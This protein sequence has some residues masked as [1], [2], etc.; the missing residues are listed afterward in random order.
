MRRVASDVS[1]SDMILAN[2]K[3]PR[4]KSILSLPQ[5]LASTIEN[6]NFSQSS[7][8]YQQ[9]LR[10]RKKICD[11]V[12]N[13][14]HGVRGRSSSST[15]KSTSSVL[16]VYDQLPRYDHLSRSARRERRVLRKAS[17]HTAITEEDN[18]SKDTRSHNRSGNRMRET[19]IKRMCARTCLDRTEPIPKWINIEPTDDRPPTNS[20]PPLRPNPPPEPLKRVILQHKDLIP[21]TDLAMIL[22]KNLDG[23]IAKGLFDPNGRKKQRKKLEAETHLGSV[24]SSSSIES[25]LH[26]SLRDDAPGSLVE[27]RV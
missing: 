25:S 17:V 14:S 8:V 21:L 2:T 5:A 9:P 26:S 19:K 11:P 1:F 20:N 18:R 16:T 15:R 23:A 4:S 12:E 22:S 24:T 7:I 10:A 13:D 3:I 27:L 6:H